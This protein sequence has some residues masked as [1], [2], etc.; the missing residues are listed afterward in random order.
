[1]LMPARSDSCHFS[2]LLSYSS[3]SRATT[4]SR[5]ASTSSRRLLYLPTVSFS[6]AT[7][8]LI[9]SLASSRA[10][11]SSFD[12]SGDAFYELGALTFFLLR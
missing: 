3:C 2:D 4:S 11:V 8:S 1:M 12:S 10:V 6:L 5:N 7:A 9:A